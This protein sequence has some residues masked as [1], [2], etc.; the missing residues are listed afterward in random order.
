[1]EATSHAGVVDPHGKGGARLY[2]LVWIYLLALTA[3]E[4]ILAYSHVFRSGFQESLP[5]LTIAMNC[6][7][8]MPARRGGARGSRGFSSPAWGGPGM[9]NWRSQMAKFSLHDRHGTVD[10]GPEFSRRSA[11]GSEILGALDPGAQAPGYHRRPLTRSS[12]S[13]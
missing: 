11:T 5:A 13:C 4:V 12:T 1:M 6:S 10:P 9:A 8:G 7:T 3:T 2:S